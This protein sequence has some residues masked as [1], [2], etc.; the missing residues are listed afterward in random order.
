MPPPAVRTR[1]ST[2]EPDDSCSSSWLLSGFRLQYLPPDRASSNRA[3]YRRECARR[4]GVHVE[5]VRGVRLRPG[6]GRP[7]SSGPM[8]RE[9]PGRDTNRANADTERDVR[10]DVQILDVIVARLRTIGFALRNECVVVLVAP[11]VEEGA[12]S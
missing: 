10:R 8:A 7:I 2:T 3:L 1:A 11:V 5:D 12:G 4:S 9:E 6:S